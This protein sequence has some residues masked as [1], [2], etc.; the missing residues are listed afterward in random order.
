ML[1]GTVLLPDAVLVIVGARLF[2]T[3]TVGRESELV[4][5][6][7]EE[8]AAV[9]SE[10]PA[11]A[12]MLVDVRLKIVV[13][14]VVVSVVVAVVIGV[15]VDIAA[16]AN[17]PASNE[18]IGNDAPVVDVFGEEASV[19][20]APAKDVIDDRLSANEAATED[21]RS[22]DAATNTVSVLGAAEEEKADE[23]EVAGDGVDEPGEAE[24]PNAEV[25]GR[26]V[27]TLNGDPLSG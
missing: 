15:M 6:T 27:A 11:E 1:D 8:T 25:A 21:T 9:I 10:G 26:P 4:C 2:S 16:S 12:P 7:D 13:V 18:L 5:E 24:E 3:G 22:V 23:D 14:A 19:E 20:E 17:E